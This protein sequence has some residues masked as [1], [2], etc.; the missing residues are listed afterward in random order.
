MYF[1]PILCNDNLYHRMII[2]NLPYTVFS[3][4]EATRFS[5]PLSYSWKRVFSFFTSASLLILYITTDTSQSFTNSFLAFSLM[6]NVRIYRRIH[7]TLVFTSYLSSMSL[8]LVVKS[9][10]TLQDT[11]Y[12]FGAEEPTVLSV[13]RSR[14]SPVYM[15]LSTSSAASSEGG[16]AG[17]SSWYSFV[18]GVRNRL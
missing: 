11:P 18:F 15:A 13:C 10:F 12:G 5:F 17:R 4:N 9:R 16:R 14:R 7:S 6:L 3:H 1:F 8:F 2:C